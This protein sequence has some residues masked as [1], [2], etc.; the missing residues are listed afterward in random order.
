MFFYG[1]K[2]AGFAFRPIPALCQ[3]Y[4]ARLGRDETPCRPSNSAACVAAA[5]AAGHRAAPATGQ[6]LSRRTR[7]RAA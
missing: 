6:P 3:R 4:A 1:L 2:Q 7:L 5:A